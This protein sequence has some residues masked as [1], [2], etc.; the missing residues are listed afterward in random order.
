MDKL[1]EV[2]GYFAAFCM[3]MIFAITMFQVIGRYFD[4]NPAGLPNYVGYLTGAST[5]LALAH[6]LNKGAHVRVRLFLSA[7]GR[8]R[9]AGEWIG[10]GFSALMGVWFSY[11]CWLTVIDS[12]NF[13]DLS[14]GLDATPLW[15]PQTSM[16][17]GA[18][19]L[20]IAV[21]DHFIRLLVT[22]SDGIETADEPL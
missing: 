10:M 20:A 15:L 13:G 14:D 6:T 11:Y 18:T 7:M 19:L 17:V 16:A 1:Y 4:Y 12:Y 3:V 9:L 5:F 8:F 22:G 2:T 21:I